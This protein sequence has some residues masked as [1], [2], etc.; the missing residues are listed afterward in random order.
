MIIRYE[1]KATF[2]FWIKFQYPTFH[3][4]QVVPLALSRYFSLSFIAS[5]RSSGLH[6]VSSNSCWMYVWGNR[7]AFTWPY[8]GVHRSTS[9]TSSSL[10]LQQC[11]PCLE[12]C[13]KQYWTSPGGNTPQSTNYTATYLLSRKLSKLDISTMNEKCK[14]VILKFFFSFFLLEG[15]NHKFLSKESKN[16]SWI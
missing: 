3:H 16:Q 10:V 11:P 5:G 13:C 7:P 2:I 15:N 12:E 6:P 8:V 4:H 1:Q 9:L 14:N